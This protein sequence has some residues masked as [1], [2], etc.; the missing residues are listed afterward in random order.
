MWTTDASIPCFALRTLRTEDAKTRELCTWRCSAVQHLEQLHYWCSISTRYAVQHHSLAPPIRNAGMYTFPYCG[1]SQICQM[2]AK[3]S[4]AQSMY[5]S[6]WVLGHDDFVLIVSPPCQTLPS[7]HLLHDHAHGL[8]NGGVVGFTTPQGDP[9]LGSYPF[10]KV[11]RSDHRLR[12]CRLTVYI[13][14]RRTSA[15]IVQL[16][17]AWSLTIG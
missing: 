1:A 10:E 5:H 9:S 12:T 2:S 15:I 17:L 16:L 11:R 4:F 13:H 7:I 3:D 6:E 14:V 8:I